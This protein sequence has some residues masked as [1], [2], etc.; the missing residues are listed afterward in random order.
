MSVGLKWLAAYGRQPMPRARGTTAVL[1]L[2]LGGPSSLDEVEPYLREVRGGRATPDTLVEEF[3]DRYRR[4]GGR[5]P[6]LSIT[7]AQARALESRLRRDGAAI[8]VFVGMRHWHPFIR[9]AAEAIAEERVERV[10]GLC[11]TPY[12]SS[13]SIGAYF[14]ALEEAREALGSPFTVLRVESWNDRPE[15]ADAFAAKVKDSLERLRGEGYQDPFLLFTA[16]SLPER[17]RSVGDPYERELAETME[18][19]QDRLPPLRSQLAYQSAG[20]TSEPWLGPSAEA[21]IQSLAGSGEKSVLVVPFGF[22]SDNLEILYDVDVEYRELASKNGVRLERTASL[23]D[24]P[25]LIDALAAAVRP[26][27]EGVVP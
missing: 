18:L 9:E 17:I 2:A 8:R 25:R 22:L 6:L 23:N 24:D 5:S 19:I 21:A 10:I 13:M 14:L 7:E 15:L 16:H 12:N 1:L 27:L 26:K 20:R 3:R 11:L 4:I